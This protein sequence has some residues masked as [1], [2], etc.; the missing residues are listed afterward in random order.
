MS[1]SLIAIKICSPLRKFLSYL[2]YII[3]NRLIHKENKMKTFNL[4]EIAIKD[5]D[6]LAKL[7]VKEK[8]LI[9]TKVYLF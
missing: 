4:P 7:F 2:V 3:Y 5:F 9:L 6:I 8:I 1:K